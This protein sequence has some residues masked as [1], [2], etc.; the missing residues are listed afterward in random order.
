MLRQR[1]AEERRK[2]QDLDRL[3]A[4]LEARLTEPGPGASGSGADRRTH[5]RHTADL[6]VR[7]RWPGQSAPMTGRLRDFSRGGLRFMAPREL[8]V[9]R[10]LQATLSTPGGP[11]PRFEG[12]MYL[13]VVYCRRAGEI[14][15]VGARFAPLPVE[16]FRSTERRHS[17]RVAVRLDMAYR[18][19]GEERQPP[20]RALVRDISRSGLRF[21]CDDRLRAG[22][23]VAAVVTGAQT[24]SAG[25]GGTRVRVSALI[26]VVR[27]RRVGGHFETGAQFVG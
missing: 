21:W 27:C 10:L 9:G 14:W 15:D 17:R 2:G 25:G 6:L 16:Q 3:L 13:E 7:Y 19:S 12:Q 26:R 18:L 22:T 4:R 11:G 5:P 1:A 8:P 23:L 20:R 24:G